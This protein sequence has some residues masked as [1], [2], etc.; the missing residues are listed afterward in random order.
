MRIRE[1]VEFM[2][3]G[4]ECWADQGPQVNDRC[5]VV[6]RYQ[7]QQVGNNSNNSYS[8]KPAVFDATQNPKRPTKHSAS[9][10]VI[11]DTRCNSLS[12]TLEGISRHSPGHY[13]PKTVVLSWK[14]FYLLGIP[15]RIQ[16]HFWLSQFYPLRKGSSFLFPPPFPLPSFTWLP[17]PHP[18]RLA[19]CHPTEE[20]LPRTE[21]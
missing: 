16:R 15:G 4:K 6:S 18:V 7:S 21:I 3:E 10:L 13:A 12:F 8:T 2:K 14:R 9:F 20:P 11:E 19:Q 1:I 5:S 17:C